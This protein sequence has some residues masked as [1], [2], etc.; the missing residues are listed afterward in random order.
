MLGNISAPGGLRLLGDIL[1]YT[2]LTC[3]SGACFKT[4]VVKS[5]LIPFHIPRARVRG[6]IF[7]SRLLQAKSG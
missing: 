4:M 6:F 7:L 1:F 5:F 2:I 3:F